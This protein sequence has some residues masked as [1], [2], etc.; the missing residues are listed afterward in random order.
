MYEGRNRENYNFN[1]RAN[2]YVGGK[3]VFEGHDLRRATLSVP[4]VINVEAQ[5]FALKYPDMYGNTP[6]AIAETA[7]SY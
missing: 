6:R 3:C 7:E 5:R 2:F 1:I 4:E